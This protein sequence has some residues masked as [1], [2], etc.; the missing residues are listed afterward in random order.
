MIAAK[1]QRVFSKVSGRFLISDGCDCLGDKRLANSWA[2]GKLA[3][4]EEGVSAKRLPARRRIDYHS[5]AGFALHPAREKPAVVSLALP[6]PFNAARAHMTVPPWSAD[7]AKRRC[8]AEWVSHQRIPPSLNAGHL[9]SCGD[10]GGR[11]WTDRAE[12]PLKSFLGK[13]GKRGVDQV[14]EIPMK[15]STFREA[16]SERLRYGRS[17]GETGCW[18]EACVSCYRS[19]DLCGTERSRELEA[20]PGSG[21]VRYCP[22]RLE[23]K[24]RKE[25][26]GEK[27]AAYEWFS[28]SGCWGETPHGMKGVPVIK[29][30]AGRSCGRQ[31]SC[32]PLR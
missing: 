27:T 20:R 3:R 9:A 5:E 12:D 14:L 10:W 1:R 18:T 15:A 23:F 29:G 25:G 21:A 19:V 17:G 31:L 24:P 13:G 4:E 28:P 30:G 11:L 7:T 26:S 8:R 16:R 22:I 6:F 2:W 32:T